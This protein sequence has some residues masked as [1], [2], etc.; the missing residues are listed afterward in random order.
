MTNH[1]EDVKVMALQWLN[2]RA[3]DLAP[4][5]DPGI[6]ASSQLH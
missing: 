3:V 2:E 6:A 1:L 5:A 4:G